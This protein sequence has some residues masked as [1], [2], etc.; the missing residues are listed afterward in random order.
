MKRGEVYFLSI[1][2]GTTTGSEIM[3]DRPCIVVSRDNLASSGTTVTVI[4]CS[5]SQRS[6]LRCHVE[7]TSTG[8]SCRAMVEQITTVDKSRL[9]HF[10]GVLTP[11]ELRRIDAALIG[12]LSLPSAENG[13]ENG[14]EQDLRKE[15]AEIVV[16][17]SAQSVAPAAT[18]SGPSSA[19]QLSAELTIYK[20]L[21][22]DLLSRV[23][24]SA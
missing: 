19:S 3:Y 22:D 2:T 23:M 6:R 10:F 17:R 24:R 12:Y 5:T 20:R 11:D 1:P 8:R 16:T 18:D 21:Y 15:E 9:G 14:E 4:P 7:I 13:E